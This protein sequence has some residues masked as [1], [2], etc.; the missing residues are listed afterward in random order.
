MCRFACKLDNWI[1]T[2]NAWW[3]VRR[4]RKEERRK[5]GI[6]EMKE[7]NKGGGS[8]ERGRKS[9]RFIHV[10]SLTGVQMYPHAAAWRC[11]CTD[12]SIDTQETDIKTDAFHTYTTLKINQLIMPCL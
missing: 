1:W 2:H 12:T 9:Q 7:S 3:Q 8:K 5:S 4:K 10:N 11:Q 6:K